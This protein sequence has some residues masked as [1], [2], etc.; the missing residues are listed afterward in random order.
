MFAYTFTFT[1]TVFTIYISVTSAVTQSVI[2]T[3]YMAHMWR[4]FQSIDPRNMELE[5]QH[6]AGAAGFEIQAR[7][8]I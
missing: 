4:D 8:R 3:Q 1:V 7:L 5:L 2:G 6:G